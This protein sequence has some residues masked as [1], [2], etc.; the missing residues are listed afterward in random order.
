MA[1]RTEDNEAI[2]NLAYAKTFLDR[3]GRVAPSR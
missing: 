2:Q 1:R 3:R